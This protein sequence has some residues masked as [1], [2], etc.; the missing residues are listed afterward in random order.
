MEEDHTT[1][2][3]VPIVAMVGAVIAIVIAIVALV[4]VLELDDDGTMEAIDTTTTSVGT[5]I[6][7]A[8]TNSL[9]STTTSEATTTESS[10]TTAESTTSVST[11]VPTDPADLRVAV[12][13]W[14]DAAAGPAAQRFD[15]PVDAATSFAVD[16]VGFTELTVGEFQASDSR[17]G[18]VALRNTDDGPVTTVFVGQLGDDDTWWI[19][20]AATEDIEID[21][22]EALEMLDNELV[23]R[24]RARTFEGNVE[25]ILRADGMTDPVVDDNVTGRGDGE[26]GAF[27]ETFPFEP[28]AAR[29][30][31]ALFVAKSAKDGSIWQAGVVRV[32]FGN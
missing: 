23:V 9:D 19:L 20:G 12:W 27:D 3:S 32:Y 4:L 29:S 18:E 31:A 14:P 6:S 7:L 16:F 15:D 13:P 25:V 24:G 2:R 22:P 11:T 1:E 21:Q 30:G 17:S 26:F 28:V 5:S 8:T 10:T